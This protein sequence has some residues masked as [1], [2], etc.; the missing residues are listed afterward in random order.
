[1]RQAKATSEITQVRKPKAW[2]PLALV[3]LSLV[4][5]ISGVVR[6]NMIAN[7]SAPTPEDMRFLASPAPVVIHIVTAGIFSVLGAFQFSS[8]HTFA[9]AANGIAWQDVY[10]SRAAWPMRSP[11]FG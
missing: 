10:W 3:L 9:G 4:P 7:G 8:V 1:M 6:L 2:L 5:V 11:G